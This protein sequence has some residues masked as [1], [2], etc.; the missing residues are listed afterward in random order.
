MQAAA[1]ACLRRCRAF[2]AQSQFNLNLLP[3]VLAAWSASVLWCAWACHPPHRWHALVV[4]GMARACAG[5]RHR[6]GT[7][8]TVSAGDGG[9]RV[10]PD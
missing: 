1:A 6:F 4:L 8:P 7:Q 10:P 3:A 5:T 9:Q 2:L